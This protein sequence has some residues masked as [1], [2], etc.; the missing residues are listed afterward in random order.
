MARALAAAI[1]SNDFP[2][3]QKLLPDIPV[4]PALWS[5]GRWRQ[6]R[7]GEGGVQM[8]HVMLAAVHNR[9][10]ILRLLLDSG[11]DVLLDAACGR[12]YETALHVACS[13]GC[14]ELAR[15]L[16]EA[17]ANPSATD[18]LGRTPLLASCLADSPE[19]AELLLA[20][21]ADAEQPMTVHNP[22]AT[23]LYAAA[24]AGSVRC[25][26]LLCEEAGAKVDA[27]TSNDASPMLVCCQDGHLEVAQLL[28][29]YGA[30]RDPIFAFCVPCG[31]EVRADGPILR[32]LMGLSHRAAIPTSY[33]PSS[34]AEKLAEKNGHTELLKWLRQSVEYPPLL[35]I[36]A[37]TPQR[38]T[39]LLRGGA[40]PVE[41][42][43]GVTA[44]ELAAKLP[45]SE[46]GRLI[47]RAAAPW[48]PADH[49]LWGAKARARASALLKLGYLIADGREL[50][51]GFVDVWIAGVLPL[52]VTHALDPP[53]APA[54]R[55]V[56]L[57]RVASSG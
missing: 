55:V 7:R 2:A 43:G 47:L 31:S 29:S 40:S 32:A 11:A 37:L 48:S 44:A 45:P 28:S 9:P 35:H 24:C 18:V 4:Y 42:H 54:A 52:A 56:E 16:L 23:P 38:T 12:D 10:K 25:A 53:P 21:G 46:A 41:R 36:E 1:K 51:R 50:D 26:C 39:A 19:C 5:D 15:M 6:R 22:G 3:V 34:Q 17:K 14:V 57:K 30:S 8:T 13:R 49:E 20:A 33:S 27:R